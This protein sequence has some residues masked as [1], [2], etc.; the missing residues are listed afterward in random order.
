MDYFMFA[1][2]L[3]ALALFEWFGWVFKVPRLPW[4]A[5]VFAVGYI[6]YASIKLR[7]LLK[8]YRELKLGRDGERTVGQEL[9][10]L[11]AQGYRVYHDFL[12]ES[13]NIDHLVIGATGV[14][15]VNTKTISKP[16]R[17][18]AKIDYDGR[19]VRVPGTSLDRDPIAQAKAERDFIRNWIQEK[20]NRNVPVR[21]AVVF[22][23]WYV[24]KQPDGA[25]VWVLNTTGLMSFIQ[26][27]R[28]ELSQDD[29]TYICGVL[30]AH[31]LQKQELLSEHRT[32]TWSQ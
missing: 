15:T 27:E 4:V 30:E 17:S 20:A 16:K 1:L 22:V 13:F 2:L 9:E 25:E 21:S 19:V 3:L 12:A 6:T 10:K 24:A 23:G 7:P 18:D 5:T 26:H 31:I 28:S 32:K 29:I 8:K 11:R 14:F